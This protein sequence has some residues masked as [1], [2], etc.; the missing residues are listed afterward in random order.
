[1]NVG[2]SFAKGVEV[3]LMEVG[4]TSEKKKT[5]IRRKEQQFENDAKNTTVKKAG[6][7]II[8]MRSLID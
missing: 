8:R 6:A 7:K 2:L 1:M 4:N 5:E 3:K